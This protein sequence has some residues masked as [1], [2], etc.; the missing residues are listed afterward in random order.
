MAVGPRHIV[1][2]HGH[3]RLIRLS[4]G[5]VLHEWTDLHGGVQLSSIMHHHD[6]PPPMALDPLRKRFAVSDGEC[7]HVVSLPEID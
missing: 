6:P 2:L 3:P 5:E 1:A 4:D 7:I